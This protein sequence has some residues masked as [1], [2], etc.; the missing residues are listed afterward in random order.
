MWPPALTRKWG[1][2]GAERSS[3]QPDAPTIGRRV[4]AHLS[5]KEK[6]SII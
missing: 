2:D 5:H 1:R 6:G 3:A 4:G